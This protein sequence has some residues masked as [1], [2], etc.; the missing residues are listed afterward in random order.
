MSILII[1]HVK[2]INQ[3]G[4]SVLLVEQDVQ[5]ALDNSHYDYVLSTGRV[6]MEGNSQ[7]L[8]RNREIKEIY[9]GV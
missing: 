6:E 1:D 3:Q 4:T 5:L 8:L 2:A 9:L 7:E